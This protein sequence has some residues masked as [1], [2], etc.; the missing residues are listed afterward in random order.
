MKKANVHEVK[1][2]ITKHDGKVSSYAS[3][4]LPPKKTT[5]NFFYNIIYRNVN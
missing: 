5:D 1:I 2:S 4:P 3:P